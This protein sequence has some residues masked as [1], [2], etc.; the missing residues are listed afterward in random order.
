MNNIKEIKIKTFTTV[1]GPSHPR[2]LSLLSMVLLELVLIFQLASPTLASEL[3]QEG[4][5]QWR[6]QLL[7]RGGDSG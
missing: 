3:I 6:S 4:F 2:L 5:R 7:R 1:R